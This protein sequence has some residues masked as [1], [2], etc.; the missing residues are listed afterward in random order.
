MRCVCSAKIKYSVSS[1]TI[2]SG[3]EWVGGKMQKSQLFSLNHVMKDV[4][5]HLGKSEG[6]QEPVRNW[7]LQK[8]TENYQRLSPHICAYV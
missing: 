1:S 5:K 6:W 4:D 8:D 7:W 2:I 3:T